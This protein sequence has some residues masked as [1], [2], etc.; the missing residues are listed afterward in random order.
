MTGLGR[1]HQFS[2]N[3]QKGTSEQNSKLKK[4]KFKKKKKIKHK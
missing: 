4:K 2:V 3:W 1:Y